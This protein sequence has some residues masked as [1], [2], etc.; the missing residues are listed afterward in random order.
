MFFFNHRATVI[1]E[2]GIHAREWV[3]PAFVT[4]MLN[5]MVHSPL[6]D[7]KELYKVAVGFE[8]YFIPVINPDGYEYTHTHVSKSYYFSLDI[9]TLFSSPVINFYFLF[10]EKRILSFLR[11]IFL[12]S[13]SLFEST[14]IL[15]KCQVK[16]SFTVSLQIIF[17][18]G[19]V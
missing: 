4:Y 17:L 16:K 19:W 6:S 12:G 1:V 3:S 11:H 15:K 5:E 10:F 14:G 9:K 18:V 8:W 7:N 2:G 13:N